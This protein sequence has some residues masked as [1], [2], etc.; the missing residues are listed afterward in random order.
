MSSLWGGRIS[1]KHITRESGVLQQLETGDNVMVDRGFEI[2]DIVP[3]VVLVNIPPF[4]GC[5]EQMTAVETS[6]TVSIAYLRNHVERT[7]RRIKNL[8]YNGWHSIQH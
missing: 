2:Q 4:L 8:S 7:I 3:D 1:D 5:R 6:K